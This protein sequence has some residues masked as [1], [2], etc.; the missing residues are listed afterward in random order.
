MLYASEEVHVTT[1][2]EAD[3]FDLLAAERRAGGYLLIRATHPRRLAETPTGEAAYVW[4]S[5]QE[6]PVATS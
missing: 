5:V 2:R 3:I 4:S 1:D 6:Q